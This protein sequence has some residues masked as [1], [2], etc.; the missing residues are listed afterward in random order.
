[1]LVPEALRNAAKELVPA[2][3]SGQD[4]KYLVLVPEQNHVLHVVAYQVADTLVGQVD[5]LDVELVAGLDKDLQEDLEEVA[6]PA[7]VELASSFENGEDA[8]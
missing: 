8:P 5:E 1:M 6:W 3:T 7:A 4:A 2:V